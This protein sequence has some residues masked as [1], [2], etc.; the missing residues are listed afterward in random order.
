VCPKFQVIL[1]CKILI[2]L[3]YTGK[4]CPFLR[5]SFLMYIHHIQEKT[6]GLLLFVVYTYWYSTLCLLAAGTS[7]IFSVAWVDLLESIVYGFI[8][9]ETPELM[10]NIVIMI[11]LLVTGVATEKSEPVLV[12]KKPYNIWKV[13]FCGKVLMASTSIIALIVYPLL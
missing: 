3:L 1:T 11:A 7:Y 13:N 12:F 10:Y 6:N 5:A 2:T 9:L 4:C 8:I